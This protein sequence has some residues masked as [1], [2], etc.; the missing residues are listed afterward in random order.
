MQNLRQ[1]N[2]MNQLSR[3]HDDEL[4]FKVMT[5]L[6]W[7]TILCTIYQFLNW[8]RNKLHC[9]LSLSI[10]LLWLTVW[11]ALRYWF[12]GMSSELKHNYSNIDQFNSDRKQGLLKKLQLLCEPIEHWSCWIRKQISFL[13]KVWACHLLRS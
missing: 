3:I 6:P 2:W 4:N 7:W 11:T 10:Y 9:L 1:I 13:S 5:I 12:N 8:L